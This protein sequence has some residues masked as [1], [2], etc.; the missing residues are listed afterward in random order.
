VGEGIEKTLRGLEQWMEEKEKG[1]ITLIEK[2]IS[3]LG[4][5]EKEE[6]WKGLR[7]G[8]VEEKSR[9]LKDV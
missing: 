4:P 2:G 1:I 3:M 7:N 9:R 5:E 8:W 6:K